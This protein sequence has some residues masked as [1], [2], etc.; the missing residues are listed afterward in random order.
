VSPSTT[1][2][3]FPEEIPCGLFLSPSLQ[4]NRTANKKKM[5]K[6]PGRVDIESG[7]WK[8]AHPAISDRHESA[9]RSTGKV[10]SNLLNLSLAPPDHMK[11]ILLF[12]TLSAVAVSTAAQSIGDKEKFAA[13][14]I[15]IFQQRASGFD[16]LKDASWPENSVPR[17]VLPGAREC[18]ISDNHVYGAI[19]RGPDSSRM[20]AL[21]RELKQALAHVAGYYKATVKFVPLSRDPFDEVFHFADSNLFTN[22]GSS[23][24]FAKTSRPEDEETVETTEAG[25]LDIQKRK[26]EVRDSFDVLLLIKPSAQVGHFTSSGEQI[27]DPEMKQLISQAAFGNDPAWTAIRTNK[28]TDGRATVYDS[29]LRLKGFSSQI[30]EWTADRKLN[31]IMYHSKTFR[32]TEEAFYQATDSLVLKVKSA[33]PAN[34]Y[35]EIFRDEDGGVVEFHPVP[36]SSPQSGYPKIR[37]SYWPVEGK[38]NEYMLELSIAPK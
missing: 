38:S 18:Y 10:N 20:L 11:K 5:Q 28:R 25:D 2:T 7:E 36:F 30:R 22:D 31:R 8:A 9:D 13:A 14:F 12:L 33:L 6:K 21:Y 27:V 4:A 26:M 15:N 35:F 23:I 29:K 3:T 32:G 1:L 19:Y 34:Y 17:I 24:S 37:I 16:S